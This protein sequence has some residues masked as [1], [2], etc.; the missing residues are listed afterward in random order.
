[1][2]D[3]TTARVVPDISDA[4]RARLY[5]AFTGMSPGDSV[6]P[7]DIRA[8]IHAGHVGQV[9][10]FCDGCGVVFEADVTGETRE[11]RF[12][13]ARRYLA[14]TVGWDIQPEYDGCPN[15]PACQRCSLVPLTGS[16]CSAH[17]SRLCHGCYRRTHFVEICTPGCSACASEGLPDGK[18]LG[19]G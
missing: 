3:H 15:C 1:M 14:E 12:A 16:C 2:T 13:A 19:R 6:V 18:A 17:G 8:A 5:A 4:V 9:G 7:D 11:D 10:I